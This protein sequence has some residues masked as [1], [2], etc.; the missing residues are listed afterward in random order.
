M[1]KLIIITF[2]ALVLSSGCAK[3]FLEKKPL[4]QI[5]VENF[6]ATS[7][8]AVKAVTAIYS[9]L[10]T[11]Q[12]FDGQIVNLVELPTDELQGNYQAGD[13]MANYTFGTD[14]VPFAAVWATLYGG[15]VDANLVCEKVPA[16][17][18]DATLKAR[19]IGEA[20]F[21]R[22]FY[23]FHL[24]NLFGG[25]PLTTK[26]LTVAEANIPRNTVEEVYA[27]IDQDFTDAAAALPLK[28][29]YGASDAG[30]ATKGAAQAMLAKSYL[31]QKKYQQAADMAQQVIQSGEYQLMPNYRDNFTNEFNNNLESIFE[32][33]N[34][35]IV[36]TGWNDQKVGSLMPQW[37]RPGAVTDA[38][39]NGR[40]GWGSLVPMPEVLTIFSDEDK[41]KAATFSVAD[42]DVIEKGWIVA[43]KNQLLKM[44][45][46]YDGT[47]PG[48]DN[49]PL[50]QRIYRYADLLLVRAEALA[51]AGD[52]EGARTELDKV[53]TRA[54]LAATTA[55]SQ[56]DMVQTIRTDRRKE[57]LFEFHRLYD[58]RRWGIAGPTL[59]AV[60]KDKYTDGKHDLF[61]IPQKQIDISR[62]ALKQN[63]NY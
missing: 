11:D 37:C 57:L 55:A 3:N 21:L 44:W 23:Y 17:E 19:L 24:V 56:A 25:V 15:I 63:P 48:A 47:D 20:K 46:P 49:D 22:G 33:Q 38:A 2:A 52:V 18:M 50:H 4:A 42:N 59:R 16:I 8:D 13:N 28:S 12:A 34:S 30:R 53:R 9:L 32:I 5:A 45:A 26:I 27:Q 43:Q 61:P 40:G 10:Q 6:Y 7:D 14:S 54:G 31:F 62:G 35:S 58:L 60:G 51:E 41:R 39:G 1:K 29:E 36:T